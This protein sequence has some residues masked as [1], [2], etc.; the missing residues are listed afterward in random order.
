MAVK[1]SAE[2]TLSYMIDIKATYRYYLLQ[3]STLA[4]PAKPTTNPPASNWTDSEPAYTVGSTSSLYY[5]DLTVFSNDT[6]LYSSVSLSTSYEAAKQAYNKAQNAQN[7]ANDAGKTATDFV[8]KDDTEGV[9]IGDKTS[10]DWSGYRTQVKSDS[11]NVLDAN[12]NVL[13]TFGANKIELGNNNENTEI[14]MCKGKS[15]ILYDPGSFSGITAYTKFQSNKLVFDATR[16]LMHSSGFNSSYT[17]SGN[18]SY[19]LS[20]SQIS[21]WDNGQYVHITSQQQDTDASGTPFSDAIEV[22]SGVHVSP[23]NVHL[24]ST[25]SVTVLAPTVS[26]DGD[27]GITGAFEPIAISVSTAGTTDA[28]LQEA[29]EYMPNGTMK[30][31]RLAQSV[32]DSL[33][34]AGTW[35]VTIY[36]TSATYGV[37]KAIRYYSTTSPYTIEYRRSIY[38]GTWSP[39]EQVGLPT[40]T[41]TWTARINAGT[42]TTQYCTYVKVGNMC[43]ISFFIQGKGS[44]TSDTNT[45]FYITGVPYEANDSARWYGGGLHVQG[46]KV[47]N[48][49]HVTGAIIQSSNNAIYLRMCQNNAEAP[50]G[51]YVCANN[52]KAV[53]YLSGS[54]TYPVA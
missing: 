51:G 23:G 48:G 2:I 31:F 36:K 34:V 11:F 22:H 8:E 49:Y 46:L 44:A 10:G 40:E 24:H 28:L 42:I 17:E 52:G 39:W 7:T 43:T 6:F 13:S 21:I 4:K 41:G 50:A 16:H 25:H 45:H 33:P 27:I 29:F 19:W 35:F 5:V 30:V 47:E 14:S 3:S 12:G 54:I 37:I 1:A 9:I 26:I 38:D 15:S 53:F 18:I 32:Q 20:Q